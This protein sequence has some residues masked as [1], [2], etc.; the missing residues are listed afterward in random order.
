L[1]AELVK[2]ATD[3]VVAEH[4]ANPNGASGPQSEALRRLLNY[5]R[6]APQAGKYVVVAE[7]RWEEYR[8]AR[9]SG[10]R[11]VAPTVLDTPA[12]ATETE[13]IHGVFEARVRDLREG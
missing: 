8:I 7:R 10:V 4:R 13:A 3:D 9:L 11:G 6:R 1:R 2:L 5:F 12:F